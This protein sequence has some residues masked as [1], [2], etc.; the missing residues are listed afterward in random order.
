MRMVGSSRWAW[1]FCP[2]PGVR[3][4][5]G[6][7]LSVVQIVRVQDN[8]FQNLYRFSVWCACRAAGLTHK[9][10]LIEEDVVMF[11]DAIFSHL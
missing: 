8:Q 10:G 9:F 1:S 7:S 4:Y 2:R 5:Q 6:G 3:F 11:L